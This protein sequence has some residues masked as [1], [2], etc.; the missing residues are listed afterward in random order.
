[1][2]TFPSATK[3]RL[4]PAICSLLLLA[5]VVPTPVPDSDRHVD[6]ES[7]LAV[8]IVHSHST[9]TA[10][11]GMA[12]AQALDADFY[13]LATGA[14]ERGDPVVTPATID[15][16]PYP[17]VFIGSPIW[18][19][20]QTKYINAFTDNNDLTGKR[21]VLFN[22]YGGHMRDDFPGIWMDRVVS[23]GGQVVDHIAVARAG[24]TQEE[25]NI[26]IAGLIAN[27]LQRWLNAAGV[28]AAE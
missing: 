20:M 15:L 10:R 27:R 1:M 11:M 4:A 19:G 28:G 2:N 23:A 24:K 21:V 3:A 22:T 26:E 17:I 16:S 25:V 12:I 14:D 13:W 9:N 7:D 6:R 5:C 8:V 18:Y